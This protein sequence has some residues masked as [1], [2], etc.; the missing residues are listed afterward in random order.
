MWRVV[1]RIP[2][3][4]DHEPCR[5]SAATPVRW[6]EPDV[7]LVGGD[8]LHGAVCRSA[9]TRG[10]SG[11]CPGA[12][13]TVHSRCHDVHPRVAV[14]GAG[15]DV[16]APVCVGR[17]RWRRGGRAA[18]ASGETRGYSGARAD[19]RAADIY[20][21]WTEPLVRRVVHRPNCRGPF[22]HVISNVRHTESTPPLYYLLEWLCGRPWLGTQSLRCECHPL[23][24]ALPLPPRSTQLHGDWE[25][26]P[27]PAPRR[28]LR[29]S[30]RSS[31]GTPRKP[32]H[33]RCSCFSA[34]W[35]CGFSC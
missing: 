20:A 14:N 1:S 24:S 22:S 15:A 9:C 32:A 23:F 3:R 29:P 13:A 27:R 5:S 8:G 16:R 12:S 6:R 2:R 21:R 7:D 19:A 10:P 34:R 33:T 4:D 11:R 31:S 28:P 25:R 17:P 35:D 18:P 26:G 30:A